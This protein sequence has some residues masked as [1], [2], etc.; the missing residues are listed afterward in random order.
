MTEQCDEKSKHQVKRTLTDR[1]HAKAQQELF[2]RFCLYAACVLAEPQ[3]TLRAEAICSSG[4]KAVAV[5][6]VRR[7]KHAWLVAAG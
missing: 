7:V 2:P 4:N 5:N 3:K 6:S 1:F